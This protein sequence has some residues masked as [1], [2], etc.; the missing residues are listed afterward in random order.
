VPSGVPAVVV[1]HAYN[2][3]LLIVRLSA[4]RSRFSREGAYV[5]FALSLACAAPSSAASACC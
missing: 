4:Q 3:N 1:G 5:T 2:P